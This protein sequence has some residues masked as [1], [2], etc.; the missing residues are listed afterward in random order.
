MTKEEKS[1][2]AV[3]SFVDKMFEIIDVD[4][5]YAKVLKQNY[6]FCK[7]KGVAFDECDYPWYDFYTWSI[8]QEEECKKWF[9]PFYAKLFQVNKRKG[10]DS[11]ENAWGFFVNTWGFQRSEFLTGRD[12]KS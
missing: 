2:V 3:E 12:G 5:T 9:L 8:L 11:A 7:E 4:M 1:K 6:E 10:E